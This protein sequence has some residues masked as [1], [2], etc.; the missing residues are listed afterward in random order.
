MSGCK[1]TWFAVFL[2][3]CKHASLR[4][5]QVFPIRLFR[6]FEAF[7]AFG[8]PETWGGAILFV[9]APILRAVK[10]EK[11]FERVEKPTDRP[12][13]LATL[14]TD[15]LKLNSITGFFF[16]VLL[17]ENYFTDADQSR[18]GR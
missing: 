14:G 11:Y 4:S 17:I 15:T 7:F 3:F 12:E 1:N 5:K 18:R 10:T 8:W 9:L 2:S 16:G 6:T 13:T